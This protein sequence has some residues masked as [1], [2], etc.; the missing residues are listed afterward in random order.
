MA[1]GDYERICVRSS[2]GSVDRGSRSYRAT[3]ELGVPSAYIWHANRPSR[4]RLEVSPLIPSDERVFRSR[5]HPSGRH[6]RITYQGDVV[7]PYAAK[8]L[9]A[10]DFGTFL[11]RIVTMD[12]N[13]RFRQCARMHL[14]IFQPGDRPPVSKRGADCQNDRGQSDPGCRGVGRSAPLI[15]IL[16]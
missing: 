2:R 6:L 16:L 15:P 10:D 9:I 14:S 8:R 4:G 5:P 13:F 1:G 12:W 11:S 3:R 7:R